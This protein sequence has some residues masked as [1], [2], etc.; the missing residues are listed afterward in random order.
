MGLSIRRHARPLLAAAALASGLMATPLLTRNASA[1]LG[2]CFLD[3]VLVLSNGAIIDL[4][5][6]IGDTSRDIQSVT[7]T[8]HVPTG[9]QVLAEY[10]TPGPLGKV[11]SF[12]WTADDAPGTYDAQTTVTTGTSS[13]SVTAL[14]AWVSLGNGGIV[15]QTVT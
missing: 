9:V 3:P 1:Q 13:I 14:M 6:L 10:R 2:P 15:S 12:S 5:D 4:S 7:Y 11:E 8:L